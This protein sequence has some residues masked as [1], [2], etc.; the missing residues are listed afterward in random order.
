MESTW[1]GRK[2]YGENGKP[3]IKVIKGIAPPAP[4]VPL[5]S[6]ALVEQQSLRCR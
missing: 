1:P 2:I 6:M 5:K 4:N 3:Q